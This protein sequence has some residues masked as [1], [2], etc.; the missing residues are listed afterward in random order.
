MPDEPLSIDPYT[1]L[2]NRRTLAGSMSGGM[3]ETQEMLDFCSE[4]GIGADVEIVAADEL[5]RAYD[6]LTAGDVR[7]RFVLDVSTIAKG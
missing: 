7:Y 1:L 4:H 2:T 3:P 5:D 6:R